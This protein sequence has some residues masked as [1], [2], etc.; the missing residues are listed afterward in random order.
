M[1][2]KKHTA[3]A[4]SLLMLALMAASL[5]TSCNLQHSANIRNTASEAKTYPVDPVF[6]EYYQDLGG[7]SRLGAA[8]SPLF[9]QDEK[10][11]QFTVAALM[12]QDPLEAGAGR[13]S[14]APLGLML[15]LPAATTQNNGIE[16][17][18]AFARLQSEM[19]GLLT[20]GQPLTPALR[21]E[22]YQRVEQFFENVA[23]YQ[24]FDQPDRAFLLPYGEKYYA[25]SQADLSISNIDFDLPGGAQTGG[26]LKNAL[27]VLGGEAVFGKPLGAEQ[28]LADGRIEQVFENVVVL[29]ENEQASL[30]TLRAIARDL[31]MQSMPPA[32]QKYGKQENM[33]FYPVEG[34]LG[35]HVPVMFDQ[36]L[37]QHGGEQLAGLPIAEP[38]LYEQENVVRQCFENLCLDYL[39]S[40]AEN[41]KVRLAPLGRKYFEQHN[42]EQAEQAA[43]GEDGGPLCVRVGEE[44]VQIAP[45]QA[46]TIHLIAYHQD[47]QSPA[48]NVEATIT[49][50]APDGSEFTYYT[51]PTDHDGRITMQLPPLNNLPDGSLVSYQA[52]L[53]TGDD[54]PVCAYESYLIW[55]VQ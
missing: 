7:E 35:F 8:I 6:R 49:L 24:P 41:E 21:N 30:V 10:S 23:F 29:A 12:C 37:R 26:N 48:A 2:I 43:S 53:D 38:M 33:V 3:T 55:G 19:N 46:Q 45:T 9:Q 17:P 50:R 14:L 28:R 52:C 18:A 5:L 22:Q 44:H 13:F 36:F 42:L 15:G 47:N 1:P 16:I 25:G 20:T 4:T 31:H 54:T 11:C 32:A 27:Q 40:A 51:P 39:S 34:G